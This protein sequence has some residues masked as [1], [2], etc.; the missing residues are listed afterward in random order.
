MPAAIRHDFRSDTV[1]RPVP[2]MR[3]AMQR[4]AVG[5][6]VYGDD[7]S[8]NQLQNR[9][10]DML[11]KEAA[12]F[13]P[14]GTQSNLIAL[15]SHCER[16]DEYIVGQNAH[17]YR[18][19]AGG[20]AVLGSIQPQPL[21]HEPDGTLRLADIETAVKP[22]DPHFARTRLLALENTIGGRVLSLAYV[23]AATALARRHGLACHLDG[24]RAFNAAV[25]L[26]VPVETVARPFDTVSIC[27]S[28]GL[29]AP[30]GSV[31]VGSAPLMAKARRLRKMLGG[32]MRQAGILAAAGL[33]ALDHHI[34]R[35][36]QDHANARALADGLSAFPGVSVTAPDT[37]IVFA[38]VAADIALPL[39]DHL[40]RHG[41]AVS[42]AYGATQQRWV[43]H[44]DVDADAVR[45]ALS[46][47]GAFFA[48]SPPA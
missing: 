14:S 45:A 30:V 23:D 19:E 16:G 26:D 13:M 12:V 2:A 43:T 15:M 48:V 18:W 47:A 17:C 27:L 28:K 25:S 39:A 9:L 31:L 34:G 7:P 3:E 1:T 11:G 24:A 8:V 46:V 35:L 10:A 29:G 41:I 36:A 21:A 33:Y 32:G 37:N 38:N 40:A 4:A 42:S 22:D 44:L 6:D 20:A 5:D